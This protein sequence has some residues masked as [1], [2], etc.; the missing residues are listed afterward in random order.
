M[1]FAMTGAAAMLPTHMFL[2][3]CGAGIGLGGAMIVHLAGLL[4][5]AVPALVATRYLP[6][7]REMPLG[8]LIAT[9]AM[10]L[11]PGLPPTLWIAQPVT[12]ALWCTA[13][14][15][16]G[17]IFGMMLAPVVRHVARRLRHADA[18]TREAA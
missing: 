3:T 8:L 2:Q 17:M 11:S 1:A 6:N 16:P 18:V 10:P 12:A 9:A 15:V 4:A 14:M 5:M 13:L 7:S